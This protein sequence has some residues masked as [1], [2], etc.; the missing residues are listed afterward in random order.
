L[1]IFDGDFLFLV[2]ADNAGGFGLE[3]HDFS[4]S[5]RGSPFGDGV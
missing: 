5:F 4:D 3:P 1:D 2:A